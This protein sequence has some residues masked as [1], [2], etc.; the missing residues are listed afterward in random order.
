MMNRKG[1]TLMELMISISL[2]SVVMI[3][4]LNLLNDLRSEEALGTNKTADLTNRTIITRI[5]EDDFYQ[6][7]ISQVGYYAGPNNNLNR[8][9]P[10]TSAAFSNYDFYIRKCVVLYYKDNTCGLLA[11][12]SA[13]SGNDFNPN[14]FM[15]AT[16]PNETGCNVAT[17]YQVEIWELTSASYRVGNAD[18]TI[19]DAVKLVKS[20]NTIENVLENQLAGNQGNFFFLIKFPA[21]I[22]EAYS[23]TSMNFD[24]EFSYYTTD[25]TGFTP[26]GGENYYLNY[27]N[28]EIVTMNPSGA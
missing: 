8:F 18:N 16:K 14:L 28:Y 4:T 21:Q 2:V 3:F 6:K 13:E 9:C 15:Y 7:G 23:N 17:N 27:T 11:V 1:F 5:V 19:D 10:L 25:T 24:L 20:E 12:G 22:P 26:A